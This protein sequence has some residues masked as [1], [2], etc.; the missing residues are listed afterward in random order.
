MDCKFQSPETIESLSNVATVALTSHSA[1]ERKAAASQLRFLSVF[2]NWNL[3][4]QLLIMAE[5]NYLRFILCKAILFNVKNEVGEEERAEIIDFILE[6]FQSCAKK[7]PELPRF[8]RTI[9]YSIICSAFYSNWR[10][11]ILSNIPDDPESRVNLDHGPTSDPADAAAAELLQKLEAF[12]PPF[13]LLECCEELIAVCCPHSGSST[14][15]FVMQKT[16]C[17]M[18]PRILD[19]AARQLSFYPVNALEVTS[20]VLLNIGKGVEDDMNRLACSSLA[21][22]STVVIDDWRSWGASLEAIL[23]FSLEAII[24]TETDEA[25][26]EKAAQYIQLGVLVDS[27]SIDFV[28]NRRAYLSHFLELAKHIIEECISREALAYHSG[29][30]FNEELLS[31]GLVVLKVV[32][33][34]D[35]ELVDNF[36]ESSAALLSNWSSYFARILK[37]FEKNL[38]ELHFKILS[39]FHS[40]F[41]TVLPLPELPSDGMLSGM[42]RLNK[43]IT[44]LSKDEAPPYKPSLKLCQIVESGVPGTFAAYFNAVVYYGHLKDEKETRSDFFN[45]LHSESMLEPLV[46]V[47]FDARTQ[48]LP[49]LQERQNELLS[50]YIYLVNMR[51]KLIS[52]T[53][54]GVSPL[55]PEDLEKLRFVE[56]GYFSERPGII[57]QDVTSSPNAL[58]EL[59][60]NYIAMTL[61]RLSTITTIF[62]VAM[63]CKCPLDISG[64]INFVTSFATPLLSREEDLTE[65]LLD[66][67]TLEDKGMSEFSEQPPTQHSQMA[68][69][70]D[71][72]RK[73]TPRFYVN[74]FHSLFFFCLSVVEFLPKGELHEEF[75]ELTLSLVRFVFLYHSNQIAL[76]HDANALLKRFMSNVVSARLFLES[77]KMLA[78]LNAVRDQSIALLNSR[79][80]LSNA[81]DSLQME[82]VRKART[83]FLNVITIFIETRFYSGYFVHDVLENLVMS[84]IAPSRIAHAPKEVIENLLAIT[85]GARQ[86]YTFMYIMDSVLER[87]REILEAIQRIIG[88]PEA[89][90]TA[91]KW[92]ACACLNAV[93]LS[94]EPELCYFSY[95]LAT[96]VLRVAN[97]FLQSISSSDG[98]S[99]VDVPHLL[100]IPNAAADVGSMYELFNVMSMMCNCSWCNLGVLIH[101]DRRS[102]EMFFHGCAKLFLATPAEMVMSDQRERSRLFGAL[103]KALEET[104]NALEFILISFLRIGLLERLLTHLAKCLRYSFCP[105]LLRTLLA[106]LSAYDRLLSR[107]RFDGISSLFISPSVLPQVFRE[108]IFLIVASPFLVIRDLCLCFGILELCYQHAEKECHEILFLLLNVCSAYHRVRVRCIESMLK[109]RRTDIVDAYV[110]VFGQGSTVPNLVPW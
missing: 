71:E 15:R 83:N 106:F 102:V 23:L 90:T 43:R 26:Q 78:V 54:V 67:L 10:Y 16:L 4:K 100:N 65:L 17:S 28:S 85:Q 22:S 63:T 34:R 52:S 29:Y 36:F 72:W 75:F 103:Y 101:Y 92:C 56:H 89:A 48:L 73:K 96:F 51:D 19:T 37:A 86:Q 59:L 21:K 82:E 27:S 39:F 77:E 60:T 93:N 38:E 69:M 61:S 41:I 97:I 58:Y 44:D 35:A 87:S 6:Y 8:L 76:V 107:L 11:F 45:L 98:E 50:S 46:Q 64:V 32:L 104:G 74:V 79:E 110:S 47:L 68:Q 1:A 55:T 99:A 109:Q 31:L 108:V 42:L 18:L 3:A 2:D 13:F 53:Q 84:Q 9:L 62:S 7:K 24:S 20:M 33:E 49:L 5:N 88:D 95:E 30:V 14:P 40:L 57:P 91:L 66:T 12:L 81:L 25:V 70:R 105:M 94:D 80:T